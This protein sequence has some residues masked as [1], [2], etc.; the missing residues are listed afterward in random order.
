MKRK[1]FSFAFGLLMILP[2]T[3]C[4]N[5]TC[6]YTAL[7]PPEFAKVPSL[8]ANAACDKDVQKFIIAG[9]SSEPARCDSKGVVKLTTDF[10][11][12][13]SVRSS[14][15]MKI[16]LDLSTSSG[17]SFD[18]RADSLSVFSA[19]IVYFKSGDGWYTTTFAPEV[20]GEWCRITL[21]KSDMRTEGKCSGWKDISIIRFSGW[22][23]GVKGTSVWHIANLTPVYE[24]ND[25]LIVYSD[26]LMK[27]R[28][29]NSL[30]QFAGTVSTTLRSLGIGS[31]M[32]ADTDLTAESFEGANA[33]V[34]PYNPSITKEAAR[35]IKE[36]SDKG[37]KLLACYST[38]KVVHD[39]FGM[40]AYNTLSPKN[41]GLSGISG[42]LRAEE[43]LDS[44][45][46]FA[47]QESWITATHNY[48]SNAK[49]VAWWADSNRKSIGIPAIVKY[50]K[51]LYMGHVWLGGSN[52]SQ[53]ELMRS[54]M[55]YLSSELTAKMNAYVSRQEAD[56]ERNRKWVAS[57][58]SKK[59]EFRAFWCHNARG[60]SNSHDWDSSIK[61]L[62]DNGFNTIIPNLCWGGVAFYKSTV[63]P[64]SGDFKKE[65]DAFDQCFAACKKYGVEMH[66]WKVCWN[67]GSYT[68]KVFKKRM[69]E[70][71]RC[72]VNADG[73]TFDGW[74]CPSNPK[75]QALEISSMIELASKKPHGIHFDYIR[76][77][78]SD[79]CYCD[80]CKARFAK[81]SGK[82]IKNW[83]GDV[84]GK[85]AI[86]ELQNS[87]REFRISNITYVVKS[88]SDVVRRDYPGVKISAA[89]FK[90]PS[91][92]PTVLGQDWPDWCKKGYVDSVHNMD[93]M[94]SPALFKNVVKRQMNAVGNAKI[95]PGI[96]LSCW[97][98]DTQSEVVLARQI[99][100]IRELGLD[101]FT[102]FNFDRYAIPVLPIL[103]L[104]ITK[105]D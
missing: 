22:S 9:T 26:S 1:I 52:G 4:G 8:M 31:R 41:A 97:P 77:K 66:V 98:G 27:K 15:D 28:N 81:F 89:V 83:P 39:I 13:N 18:F 90:S 102:I 32:I 45:P 55:G 53:A 69:K 21:R 37:G 3:G 11:N 12:V 92:D 19:L 47:S 57:L 87:W 86:V 79:G 56:K 60:L 59:N 7:P 23:V 6:V 84:Y 35:L 105:E 20:E 71:N 14:W 50:P 78:G 100:A 94:V 67:L 25:V 88:V 16:P 36:Y 96:G 33:V 62:K 44:Q 103:R 40:K 51:G 99:M 48:G 93:Y 49:V 76:Y 61:F 63:L 46:E 73:T 104:G 95:Y 75:N 30:F 85:S 54:L 65:G 2:L 38:P 101:G 5:Q 10:K 74:L 70:E 64:M 80:G 29:D 34:L 17:I 91:N 72:L 68:S 82:E 43:G 42:F 58:P 24:P